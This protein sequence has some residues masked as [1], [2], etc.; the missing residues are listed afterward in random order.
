MAKP[1]EPMQTQ[2]YT[3]TLPLS[4]M[5]IGKWLE[6]HGGEISISCMMAIFHVRVNWKKLHTYSDDKGCHSENWSVSRH[7]QDLAKALKLATEAAVAVAAE[8]K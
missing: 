1:K 3:I 2:T 5:P 4:E 6:T 8:A 7:D